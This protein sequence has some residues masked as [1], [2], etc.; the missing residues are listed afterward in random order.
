MRIRFFLIFI[1]KIFF[2]VRRYKANRSDNKLDNEVD[3]NEINNEKKMMDLISN[4]NSFTNKKYVKKSE[5]KGI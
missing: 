2:L 4:K 1:L 5:L 3:E